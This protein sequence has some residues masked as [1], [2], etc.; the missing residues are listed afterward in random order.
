MA[1]PQLAVG[2]AQRPGHLDQ[3]PEV[4]ARTRVNGHTAPR[5]ICNRWPL[6][7]INAFI[8][9]YIYKTERPRPGWRNSH[10]SVHEPKPRG[11]DRSPIVPF[12]HCFVLNS[13]TTRPNPVLWR[14]LTKATRTGR[15]WILLKY[16][17]RVCEFCKCRWLLPF[18][19]TGSRRERSAPLLGQQ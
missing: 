10:A 19:V 7:G 5:T 6:E 1:P 18:A 15:G 9:I 13:V 8:Y 12:R 16:W 4:R 17:S 2:K 3:G 14:D 11:V